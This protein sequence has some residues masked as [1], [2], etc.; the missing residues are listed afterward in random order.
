[1]NGLE[2]LTRMF[3]LHRVYGRMMDA[4]HASDIERTM[5]PNDKEF[6]A[7]GDWSVLHYFDVGA[8]A[9]RIIVKALI[10]SLREPPRSI[11]DFPCGS[12]RVTRHLRH[13]FPEAR[14]VASDL[15]DYHVN[16][17]VERF[18]AD[19]V[20]SKE[21]PDDLEFGERFNLIFCGSLLTHLPEDLFRAT[22]RLMRRSL[23]EAGIAVVTI[24]GRHSNFIQKHKWKYLDDQLYEVAEAT[25][26]SV[27]FGY[28]DYQHDFKK[29]FDQQVRYGIALTRPR[30]SLAALEAANDI[31]VLS[32]IE[33]EWDDHQDVL[34]FGRPG[35]DD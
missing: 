13:F 12:G 14:I 30:W 27:G 7:A 8:D 32:Y 25:L 10:G 15:Y 20:L 11:L 3:E 26:P 17:C 31:R 28:V 29:T 33:R 4:Y 24:H 35:I 34:V 18:G 21:N 23:S 1:M 2:K 22:L 6:V 19:G 5:D 16:F 9:L